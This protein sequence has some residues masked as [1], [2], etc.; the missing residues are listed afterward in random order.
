MAPEND[1]VRQYACNRLN[2]FIFLTLDG[3]TVGFL[4][5]AALGEDDGFFVGICIRRKKTSPI[6]MIAMHVCI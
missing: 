1:E 6:N 5:G 3:P 2:F 4:V